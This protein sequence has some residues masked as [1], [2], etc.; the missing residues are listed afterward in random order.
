[1]TLPGQLEHEIAGRM[2]VHRAHRPDQ[3]NDIAPLEIM[4]QRVAE[5]RIERATV[6]TADSGK[7]RIQGEAFFIGVLRSH[8]V[9]ALF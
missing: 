9:L 3:R 1:L 7:S 5:Y 6:R 4:R 8:D 2:L